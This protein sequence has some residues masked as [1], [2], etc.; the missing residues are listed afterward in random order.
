MKMRAGIYNGVKNVTLNEVDKPE[1]TPNSIIIKN[2]RSGICGTD[3]HAYNVEGHGVGIWEG[4]QFG[5]E[6]CGIIA[7]VG[8]NVKDFIAGEHIFVNPCTFETP[9]KEK[10]IL[11]CCDMAGAFS[12]YVKCDIPQRE[13]N[14]F[15]LNDKLSW[16]VAALIEPLSVAMNGVVLTKP[17]KGEKA[18]VYGAGIIGLC[19][20]ACLKY[21]GVQDVIVSDTVPFRLERVKQ[22]GGIPCNV[23]EQNVSDFAKKL[24]GETT[25]NNGESNTDADIVID[26]A[27]YRGALE[28]I[29]ETAKVGSRIAL[30]AL[31][32]SEEKV[33]EVNIAYK[34]CA[35]YGSFAYTPAVNRMVIDMIE[36]DEKAV[37][38]IITA[39]YGL[40]EIS[41]AFNDACDGSKNIKVLIDHSK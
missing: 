25:G 18:I 22:M 16:D 10:S 36:K 14:I 5:H 15:H 4:N 26:C 17:Q 35:I 19:T 11:M 34:A 27:G 28:S 39:T 12:E 9:T 23:K 8:K 1:I 13:Y 30:V 33:T 24:W 40:S 20:L 7:E 32:T 29:L 37:L 3:L 21:M 2:V 31:G 6:M 38:P 41:K